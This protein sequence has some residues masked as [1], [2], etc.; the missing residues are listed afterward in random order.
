MGGAVSYERGTPV[1][2]G[3]KVPV[4]SNGSHSN[5]MTRL[6]IMFLVEGEWDLDV[7]LFFVDK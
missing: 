4:E 7:S 2:R 3:A 1:V 5:N 6:Y